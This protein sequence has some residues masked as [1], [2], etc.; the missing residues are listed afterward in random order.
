MASLLLPFQFGFFYLFS[1]HDCSK[2][3]NTML[4]RSDR[5]AHPCLAPDF[6]EIAFSFSPLS[7]MLA[8]PAY[9]NVCLKS[10]GQTQKFYWVLYI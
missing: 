5:S 10:F 6:R 8:V 1:F 4:N 7:M 3:S 2:T 9:F